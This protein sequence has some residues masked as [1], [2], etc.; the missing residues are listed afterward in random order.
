MGSAP[1]AQQCV[2]QFTLA[3]KAAKAAVGTPTQLHASG[4]R[5]LREEMD[6]TPEAG[7]TMMHFALSATD[8]VLEPEEQ[9]PGVAQ[10][11]RGHVAKIEAPIAAC[12]TVE[13][14]DEG[15]MLSKTFQIRVHLM[16][17]G[18]FET[19]RYRLVRRQNRHRPS[20]RELRQYRAQLDEKLRESI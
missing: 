2:Q 6:H 3:A 16:P 15:G 13:S 20:A 17:T 11:P 14:L 18:G 5:V 10:P 1:A 4:L 7:H 8:L 19:E 12:S 9:A